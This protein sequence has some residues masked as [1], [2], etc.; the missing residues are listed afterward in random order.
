M[1]ASNF[2]GDDFLLIKSRNAPD[3]TSR[4]SKLLNVLGILYHLYYSFV[5]HRKMPIIPYKIGHKYR[6][7]IL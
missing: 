2:A 7:A 3:L 5:K 1:D 4:K 6:W